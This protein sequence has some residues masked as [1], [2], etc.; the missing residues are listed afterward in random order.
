MKK[1]RFDKER[2]LLSPHQ[3]I[4]HH[5]STILDHHFTLIDLGK[6]DESCSIP[7][8]FLTPNEL[9]KEKIHAIIKEKQL[10]QEQIE[11]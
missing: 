6:Q 4:Q 9:Y 10:D 1:D 8:A 5:H 11:L 2:K 7:T 3:E